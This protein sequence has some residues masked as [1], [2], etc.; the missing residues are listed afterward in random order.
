MTPNYISGL[1]KGLNLQLT[2]IHGRYTSQAP[3]GDFNFR[4]APITF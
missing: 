3:P 4:F 1:A 2:R